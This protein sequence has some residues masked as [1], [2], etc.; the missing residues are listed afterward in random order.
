MEVDLEFSVGSIRATLVKDSNASAMKLRWLDSDLTSLARCAVRSLG[1][2]FGPKH[3]ALLIDAFV[4]TFYEATVLSPN[5]SRPHLECLKESFGCLVAAR[6]LL[7]GAFAICNGVTM[8]QRPKS[9]NSAHIL[10]SLGMSVLPLIVSSNFVW[11]RPPSNENA[12][13]NGEAKAP[14]ALMAQDAVAAMLLELVQAFCILLTPNALD[15]ALSTIL[16]P[17]VEMASQTEFDTAQGAALRVLE[18]AGHTLGRKDVDHMVHSE[19]QSLVAAMLG[20]LRLPG[21]IVRPSTHD[22]RDLPNVARALRW[23]LDSLSRAGR[24][25]RNGDETAQISML[26]DLMSILEENF[27]HAFYQKLLSETAVDSLCALHKSFF[28]YALVCFGAANDTS[29]S[30]GARD[31]A[32][33]SQPSWLDTLDNFREASA[34]DLREETDPQRRNLEAGKL[35]LRTLQ[36]TDKDI[37]L[38]SKIICR[39]CYLLSSPVLRIKIAS[40]RGLVASFRFLAFVG[41]V[42]EVLLSIHLNRGAP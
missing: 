42:H 24:D 34:I 36:V 13:K 37:H 12:N 20:S 26:V 30:Y 17:V 22:V 27:D 25:S 5:Q 35:R 3:S 39:N 7:F 18:S 4:S 31:I 32:F 16:Y 23:T 33:P 2:S 29:Y 21:G 6:E 38:F 15:K 10:E 19:A 11:S 14:K 9:A 41:S 8:I 28:E 40:S 1:E